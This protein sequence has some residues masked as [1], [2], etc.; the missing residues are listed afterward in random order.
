MGPVRSRRRRRLHSRSRPRNSE[1]E[2]PAFCVG[3]GYRLYNPST[4]RWPNRD[5]LGEPGFELTRGKRPDALGDGPNLY[6]FVANLPVG[7]VDFF[8]LY[9]TSI[10]AA[11]RTCMAIPSPA[12]RIK[13]L[14]D[15]LDTIGAD[16]AAKRL[17]EAAMCAEIHK[18]YKAFEGPGCD[19]KKYPTLTPEEARHRALLLTAQIAGRT[20]YLRKKCDYKLA[21]SIKAGSKNK[22]RTHFIELA[23][24][25]RAL[26]TCLARSQ[27]GE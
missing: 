23:N 20:L 22:E 24:K 3:S 4:G 25:K 11:I 16:D 17:C 9:G 19:P 13:C 26:A 1:S 14:I 2:I 21:G 12:G 15:V 8:G 10:D 7:R 5:P 27:S 18:A 6:A